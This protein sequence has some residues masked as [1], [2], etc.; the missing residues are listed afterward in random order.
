MMKR[1]QAL[2]VLAVV[3]L[4]ICAPPAAPASAAPSVR[5]AVDTVPVYDGKSDYITGHLWSLESFDPAQYA[6]TAYVKIAQSSRWWGPKPYLNSPTV[7]PSAEATYSLKFNTGGTDHLALEIVLFLLPAGVKPGSD[8]ASARDAALDE[9]MIRRGTDGGVSIDQ[10]KEPAATGAPAAV[11]S[12]PAD[13]SDLGTAPISSP[14]PANVFLKD[15]SSAKKLSL[16]F[17]PY[18][19]GLSPEKNDKVPAET[20]LRLLKTIA[21]YADTVRLFGVSGELTKVYSQAK[22]LGL[23]VIGGCWF[24][25]HY[26][27]KMIYAELDELIA[28]ANDGLLSVAVVGS[29]TLARRDATPEALIG[30]IEYVRAGIKDKS[31]PVTTS[32]TSDAL[33]ANPEVIKACTGAVCFTYYPYFAGLSSADAL[34]GLTGAY[35]SVKALAGDKAVI[36]S[37]TGH[38]MKGSAI[39]E[40]KPGGADAAKYVSK[41]YDWSRK[42]DVEVVFFEGFDEQW[43]S[44]SGIDVEPHWGFFY[45]GGTMKTAYSKF[46][47]S[48]K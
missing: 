10:A 24:D 27:E 6:V 48:V 38:P 5:L 7:K 2:V 9:V 30:Y 1:L 14:A 39:G 31:L 16:N 35:Q 45:Q 46:L 32:D 8:I 47:K 19:G 36:V 12:T 13:G 43:K 22:D 28:K 11:A 40:S 34:N 42:N 21:P 41:V 15:P 26:T 25:K 17:S 29:E 23:R 33:L 4:T 37:E 20:T 44:S 3:F 18:V